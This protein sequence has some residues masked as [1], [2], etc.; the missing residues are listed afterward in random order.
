M[1]RCFE[2]IDG[3]H[4]KFW[5]CETAGKCY[6]ATF[7]RIGTLGQTQTKTFSHPSGAMLAANKMI[8]SKLAKG[9]VETDSL[10]YPG[11]SADLLRSLEEAGG[12]P[13]ASSAAAPSRPVRRSGTEEGIRNLDL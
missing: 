1:R 13:A 4:R 8:K 6:F 11:A 5:T 2:L 3:M 10:L 12:T 9:Y 7:G